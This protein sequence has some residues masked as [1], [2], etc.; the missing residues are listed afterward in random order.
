V[1]QITYAQALA[2]FVGSGSGF[3]GTL[4]AS[5]LSGYQADGV[6]PTGQVDRT[7]A[8]FMAPGQTAK[9]YVGLT[10]TSASTTVTVALETVTA[11]KTFYI[12]DILVTT[13]SAV[14]TG[15]IVDVSILAAAAAIFRT[16]VHSLVPADFAG[17]ETQPFATAGQAVALSILPTTGQTQKVWYNI[18]GFEQ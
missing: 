11:G 7:N 3:E 17:I 4:L 15:G 5:L 14:G 16:G 12:T 10:T 13:D 6:T 18:Y 8:G 1:G 9:Q 2:Q